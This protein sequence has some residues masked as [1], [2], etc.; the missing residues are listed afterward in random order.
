MEMLLYL[1]KI[2]MLV[3]NM[4]RT[5]GVEKKSL[6]TYFKRGH[7]S[8]SLPQTDKTRLQYLKDLSIGWKIEGKNKL[9]TLD[10]AHGFKLFH[11]KINEIMEDHRLG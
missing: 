11:C 10:Q 6:R 7:S 5:T 1:S 2:H 3:Q 9:Q 4:E 8:I